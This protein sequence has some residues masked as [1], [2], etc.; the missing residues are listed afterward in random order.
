MLLNKICLC[1]GK[2]NN[3]CGDAQGKKFFQF[4]AGPNITTMVHRV[5]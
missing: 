4:C 3:A 2:M 1:V 5:W